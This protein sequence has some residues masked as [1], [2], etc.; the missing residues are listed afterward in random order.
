MIVKTCAKSE[1]MHNLSYKSVQVF[2]LIIRDCHMHWKIFF[3]FYAG[4]D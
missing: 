4:N 3:Q 2:E 1:F